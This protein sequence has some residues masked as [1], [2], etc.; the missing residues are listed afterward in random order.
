MSP[1]YDGE[2]KKEYKKNVMSVPDG[3]ERKGEA[4][5]MG[6]VRRFFFF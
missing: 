6:Q 5:Q 3:E 1:E 2:N 4:F